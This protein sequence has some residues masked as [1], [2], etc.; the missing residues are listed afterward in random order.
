MVLR[1]HPRIRGEYDE[2]QPCFV[3][4]VGSPPHTRGILHFPSDCNTLA[5]SPP[6]TRGILFIS[7]YFFV[8]LGITPAYAGNTLFSDKLNQNPYN[9]PRIRGEYILL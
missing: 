7:I 8:H 6:H 1:D 5:G 2:C 9:H 4:S 3:D